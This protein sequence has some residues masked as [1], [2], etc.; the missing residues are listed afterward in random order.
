LRAAH[1]SMREDPN[2]DKPMED[3][4]F[5]GDNFQ[6]CA[7]AAAHLC[8]CEPCGS[9]CE[10]LTPGPQRNGRRAELHARAA[11]CVGC[12]Q[13]GAG[14]VRARAVRVSCRR[15]TRVC[16]TLADLNAAGNP[17]QLAILEKDVKVKKAVLTGACVCVCVRRGGGAGGGGAG[18]GLPF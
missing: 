14:R 1:R 2:P 7:A 9:V 13:H 17:T 15:V 11:V 18:R 5:A 8:V 10:P 6:R 3:K 4:I 12:V 16:R